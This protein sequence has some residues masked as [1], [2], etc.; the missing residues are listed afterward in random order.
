MSG[1]MPNMSSISELLGSLSEQDI[2]NLKNVASS[3][4]S[5]EKPPQEPK[6]SA[7]DFDLSSLMGIASVMSAISSEKKD[8][9][10][11][12]LMA[13]RPMVAKE[14]QQK[15]DQAVKM[16]QLAAVFKAIGANGL[17]F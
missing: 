14:R 16:L 9:R 8:P 12:L 17:K 5:A 4:F 10:C 13:L 1:E 6:K 7:P 11:D 15:I 2:E 3:M